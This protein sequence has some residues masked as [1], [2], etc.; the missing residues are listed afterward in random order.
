MLLTVLGEQLVSA[1]NDQPVVQHIAP[2]SHA[3]FTT[4]PSEHH[5]AQCLVSNLSGMGISGVPSQAPTKFS[6]EDHPGCA[7]YTLHMH[8]EPLETHC[9]AS[10]WA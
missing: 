1:A 3:T 5:Q 4:C 10:V 9:E 8:Q 2:V 6:A 7:V